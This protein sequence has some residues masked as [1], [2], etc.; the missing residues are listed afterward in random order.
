MNKPRY[1]RKYY[2][3]SPYQYPKHIPFHFPSIQVRG[4]IINDLTEKRKLLNSFQNDLRHGEKRSK[5]GRQL[6]ILLS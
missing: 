6:Q 1:P 5:L 2:I 4:N 3:Q